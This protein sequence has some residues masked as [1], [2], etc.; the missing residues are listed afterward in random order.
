MADDD[1]D[2]LS[3]M[4]IVPRFLESAIENAVLELKAA[5]PETWPRWGAALVKDWERYVRWRAHT[6]QNPAL[7]GNIAAE[8]NS[9]LVKLRTA[10]L[11]MSGKSP[12][13][14]GR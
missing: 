13:L 12:L 11:M 6:T 10:Q 7:L 1:I 4:R 3:E 14:E 5:D 9:A 2:A 8:I